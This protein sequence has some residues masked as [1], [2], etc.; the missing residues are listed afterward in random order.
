[1]SSKDLMSKLFDL[2]VIRRNR[3]IMVGRIKNLKM[4]ANPDIT[5]KFPHYDIVEIEV[6]EIKSITTID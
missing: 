2:F 3:D 1:M 6:E 5:N 4:C